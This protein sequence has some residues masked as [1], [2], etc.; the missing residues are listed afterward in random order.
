MILLRNIVKRMTD[1]LS[2]VCDSCHGN[3]CNN[4]GNTGWK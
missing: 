3:G 4:C 2:G 1:T